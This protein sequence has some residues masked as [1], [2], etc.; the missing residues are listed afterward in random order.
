MRFNGKAGQLS[1]LPGCQGVL[2]GA[3]GAGLR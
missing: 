3:M 2:V 1:E